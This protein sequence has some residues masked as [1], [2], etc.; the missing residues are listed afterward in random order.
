VSVVFND[1][2]QRC[3]KNPGENPGTP[4]RFSKMLKSIENKRDI[5]LIID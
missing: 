3:V 2:S 1:S 4:Y 5:Y